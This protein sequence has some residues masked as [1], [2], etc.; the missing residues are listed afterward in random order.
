MIDNGLEHLI[1]F[2]HPDIPSPTGKTHQ[3]PLGQLFR[4][5]STTDSNLCG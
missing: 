5:H 3:I 1:P 2:D 4:Q